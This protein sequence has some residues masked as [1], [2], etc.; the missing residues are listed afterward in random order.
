MV[1]AGVGVAVWNPAFAKVARWTE[2]RALE[3]W[4]FEGRAGFGG[5]SQENGGGC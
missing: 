2:E 4:A 3:L 5:F 1:L